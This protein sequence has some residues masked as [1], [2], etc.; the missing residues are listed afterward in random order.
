MTNLKLLDHMLSKKLP[1]LISTGIWSNEDIKYA[2]EYLEAKGA[3]FSLLLSNSTYPCPYE[4]IS[5]SYLHKLKEYC[6]RTV[7]G[8]SGHE[9]G[10]YQSLLWLWGPASSRS[11]SLLTRS[12]SQSFY[13][14][15]RMG[16]NGTEH[17]TSSNGAKGWGVLPLEPI[18]SHF[19]QCHKFPSSSVISGANGAKLPTP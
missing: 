10:L 12:W 15:T 3:I 18:F 13:G 14:A 11:I 17:L 1:L 7:V 2:A 5:L 4:D 19:F 16:R 8:Y 6:P 9:R